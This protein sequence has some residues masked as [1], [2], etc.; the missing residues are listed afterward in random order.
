[1]SLEEMQTH[2]AERLAGLLGE[3]K[4]PASM[5]R[6][7]ITEMED[8]Y[9]DP[10]ALRWGDV[11]HTYVYE[12]VVVPGGRVMMGRWWRLGAEG[13]KMGDGDEYC[14]GEGVW[15]RER[16]PFVFWGA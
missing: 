8:R 13:C 1:M 16:G 12:G 4:G 2:Y 10:A 15:E 6:E 14:V 7:R 9:R 3:L 11:D 5:T